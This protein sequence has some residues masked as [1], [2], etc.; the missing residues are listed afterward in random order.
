MYLRFFKSGPWVWKRY[1]DTHKVESHRLFKPFKIFNSRLLF[2]K[3]SHK[4]NIWSNLVLVFPKFTQTGDEQLQRLI[5]INSKPNQLKKSVEDAKEFLI[6]LANEHSWNITSVD[7]E[8]IQV[9]A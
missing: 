5:E 4:G 8:G 9:K 1:L 6:K 7:E 2:Q 3:V